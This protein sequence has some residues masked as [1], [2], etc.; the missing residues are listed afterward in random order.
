[1][2][3]WAA[4]SSELPMPESFASAFLDILVAAGWATTGEG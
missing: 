2:A 3:W 1:V 4:L